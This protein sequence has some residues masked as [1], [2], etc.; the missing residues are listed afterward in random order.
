MG[1]FQCSGVNNA[2]GHTLELVDIKYYGNIPSGTYDGSVWRDGRFLEKPGIW[3]SHQIQ[4]TPSTIC[5][6]TYVENS[7]GCI[8]VGEGIALDDEKGPMVTASEDTMNAILEGVDIEGTKEED[9]P[10]QSLTIRNI[11]IT[12]H[13]PCSEGLPIRVP[14]R[15][16]ICYRIVRQA[17][18]YLWYW[19]RGIVKGLPGPSPKLTD[20]VTFEEWFTSAPWWPA[21][22]AGFMRERR[23]V[24]MSEIPEDDGIR[25]IALSLRVGDKVEYFYPEQPSPIFEVRFVACS[26]LSTLSCVITRDA[27]PT[28]HNNITARLGTFQC[29]GVNSASGHTLELENQLKGHIPTG[30]YDGYVRRDPGSKNL[31]PRIELKNVDGFERIQIHEGNYVRNTEACILPGTRRAMHDI[32]GPMVKDSK[33]TMKAILEG[34]EDKN[35]KIII[36]V[37][38]GDQTTADAA[39]HTGKSWWGGVAMA[40]LMWAML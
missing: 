29:S 22:D 10:P 25:D 36:T 33:P 11:T 32:E 7:N 26:C 9:C 17:E 27:S 6:G 35:T 5:Q 30:T 14:E 31:G 28:T 4:D 40:V 3:L 34:V 8:L 16:D 39:K 19:E 15:G 20:T 18:D 23:E 37:Q 13:T 24:P 1:T 2:F 21:G 38:G 12:I